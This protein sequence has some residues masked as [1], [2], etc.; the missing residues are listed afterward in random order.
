[1]YHLVNSSDTTAYYIWENNPP[2]S[3]ATKTRA[4]PNGFRM[5]GGLAGQGPSMVNAGCAGE[6]PCTKGGTNCNS[7][8][9]S[10]FP[11][12]ACEE[13]EVEMSFPSCWDGTNL[14]SVDHISHVAYTA[15]GTAGEDCP[16]THPVRI[17]QLSL[18]FRIFNYRGG[19]YTFSDDTSIFHAD[20]ISGWEETVLQNVLDSC[21]ESTFETESVS[22]C[23]WQ[24]KVLACRS[25]H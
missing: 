21:Q 25:F 16:P 7:P 2:V 10:L 20:Y 22:C 19:H 18:F 6:S 5:I 8:N 3:A 15:E 24:R 17:P 9:T 11:A 12:T 14:D 23:A 4:F 13:L 1:M